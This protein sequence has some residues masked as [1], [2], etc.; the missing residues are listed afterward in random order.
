MTSTTFRYTMCGLPILSDFEL[1]ELVDTPSWT[2]DTAPAPLRVTSR[3]REELPP[4]FEIDGVANFRRMDEPLGGSEFVADGVARLT[5]AGDGSAIV[6]EYR[7][8]ANPRTLSHLVVDQGVPRALTE[9]GAMVLH[10]TCVASN[11]RGLGFLGSTGTGKSTFAMGLVGDGALLVADDCLVLQAEGDLLFALPSYASS[12]LRNDSLAALDLENDCAPASPG[13][14]RV[15]S[16][17]LREPV[18]M[19]ALFV[20]NRRADDS[21][22][23][24]TRLHGTAALWAIALHAFSS[25]GVAPENALIALAIL[26]P[27]VERVPIFQLSYPSGFDGL[28]AAR[29]EALRVLAESDTA[30]RQEA[31]P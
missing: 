20:L 22:P 30:N 28:G 17:A 31:I 9:R 16:A 19:A 15:F 10:A 4:S 11:G 2:D 26:R 25:N 23:A 29:V 24:A 18:P 6:V 5:T 3:I 7:S 12:R 8:S 14:Q 1:P 27:I 13:K 21:K